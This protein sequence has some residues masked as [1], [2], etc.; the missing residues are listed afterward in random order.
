MT[1]VDEI[2]RRTL[3][4][5]VTE[6]LADATAYNRSEMVPPTVVLWPDRERQWQKLVPLLR[7]QMAHLLTLGEFDPATSTGPAVWIKCAVA[8]RL[9]DPT[10]APDAAPIIYLPGVSRAELRAVE[11]CAPELQPLA[12]LQYRGVWFTQ[13]ST[14]DWTLL[15]FLCSKEAGLGLDV[16]RD[17]AT[18]EALQH[19]LLQLARTP[20]EQLAGKTITHDVLNGLVHADPA[21]AILDW[22]DEPHGTRER[23]H[24]QW[25]SFRAICGK[26]YDFDPDTDGRLAGA[27]RLG[28]RQGNWTHVW[29]RFAEAPQTYVRVPELLRKAQPAFAGSLFYDRSSWPRENDEQEVA[30]RTA[31][32]ALADVPQEKAREGME[33]LE[34]EHGERRAWVW[35][36]LG[37]A[38]LA[39]ALEHLAQLASHTRTA[40]GGATRD[41]LAAAYR[42]HGWQADAA[43]V[44][45]LASVS[46]PADEQA[47]RAAVRALYLPWLEHTAERLQQLAKEEPLPTHAAG[48]APVVEAGTCLL[49]V[50]GMR[51][52]VGQR[53]AAVVRARGWELEEAWR[54][55]ALPTVTATAKPAAAPIADLVT[56]G[57]A[58][59]EF[60][61]SVAATGATLSADR[62]RQLLAERG[63]AYLP[64]SEQGD[65]AGAAWTEIGDLDRRG[66][67]EGARLARRVDESV[68]D[69]L[70]RVGEL[71]DAGWQRV[72][73]VTDHGW[74][75]M[76]GGL[77]KVHLPAYLASSRWGRCA[78]L[79]NTSAVEVPVVPWYWNPDARVALA[80][81]IGVFVDGKEYAHGGLT[82]QEVVVPELV[83]RRAAAATVEARITAVD[84]VNLRCKLTVEGTFAG[85]HADVRT[86][87]NVAKSSVAA[88]KEVPAS[89]QVSLVVGDDS[90]EGSAAIVV[91]VDGAGQVVAKHAT[92]IG[93]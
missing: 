77:P 34:R 11:D 57:A 27:E 4:G 73:L 87:P 51:Y 10:I 67:D 32:V 7:G 65:P 1:T 78:A 24:D 82:L 8:R 70:A 42:D 80:P 21:R 16:A 62:F 30:L 41:E 6:A 63:I 2:G 47:V 43:A 38:P 14:K 25:A 74:L 93:G 23:D 13:Q 88:S 33:R 91:L 71:L 17:A 58:D 85:L 54:W 31:L 18:L 64:R 69:I 83:V 66:H 9:E 53:I 22:L 39:G 55:A 45:A 19:T 59:A 29:A 79:K 89:G 52:D 75:L 37:Q 84:W 90:L 92:T 36:R 86:K 72:S 40:L 56:G 26:G 20:V 50:D 28:S 3:I 12:E 5:A 35:A 44:D 60:C 61:A 68:E 49:F 48:D 46:S 81:G 76:P 15:A